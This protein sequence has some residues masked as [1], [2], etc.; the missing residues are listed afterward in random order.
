[1]SFQKVQIAGFES[2]LVF[3][4]SPGSENLSEL[5]ALFKS[6]YPDL[7]FAEFGLLMKVVEF[8]GLPFNFPREALAAQR[9]WN[10]NESFWKILKATQEL[11]AGFLKWCAEKKMAPM[12]C[13][14]LLVAQDLNL[15]P[16]LLF[17]VHFGFSKSQGSQALEMGI[18]LL[19]LGKSF[20]DLKLDSIQSR[21]QIESW[22]SFLR[23]LRYPQTQ[24]RD[25]EVQAY[26]KSLPWPGSSQT[27]WV[28]QGDKS[29]L[30]IKLF[31]AQPSDLKRY[32]QSLNKVQEQ[33]EK[34]D[35]N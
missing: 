9:G 1:M 13:S 30:E 27:R 6:L 28:R 34:Q 17:I 5:I 33:L 8:Q 32:L 35:L 21:D 18:E 16:L 12:E 15:S 3:D 24:T 19:L 14:P 11:P 29:G 7:S 31:V 20:A 22:M 26:F 23:D 25:R 4:Y 10:T 2:E